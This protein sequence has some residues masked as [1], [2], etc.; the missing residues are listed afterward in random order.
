M[1]E[2][3]AY[4]ITARVSAE[5]G[6]SEM[7]MSVR[8]APDNERDDRWT[9]CLIVFSEPKTGRKATARTETEL[10]TIVNAWNERG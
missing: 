3:Q 9:E 7:F 4:Q 1:N 6:L 2:T 5:T 8:P 10:S